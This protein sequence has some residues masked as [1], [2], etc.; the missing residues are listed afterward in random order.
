LLRFVLPTAIGQVVVRDDVEEG[1]I[2]EALLAHCPI[3]QA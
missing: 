2:L 1:T 3:A